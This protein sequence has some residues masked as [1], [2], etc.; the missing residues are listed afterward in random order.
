MYSYGCFMHKKLSVPLTL[1]KSDNPDFD[2]TFVM[3]AATL[4]RA[5]D[6]IDVKAY[7]DVIKSTDKIIALFNHCPDKICGYWSDLKVKGDTLVGSI[8]LFHKD[9]GAMCK[10]MLDFGIPLGASLG[11]IGEGLHRNTY[12]G[13]YVAGPKRG[14]IGGRGVIGLE[15]NFDRDDRDRLEPFGLN[16]IVFQRGAGLMIAGNKTAQQSIKSA[17]SS[18]DL[19]K[20]ILPSIISEGA[21]ISQPAFA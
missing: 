21:I 18:A 17:L 3:S 19:I 14:I 8:K 9:W 20:P 15:K 12:I 11:F 13:S 7:S 4:D 10:E 1:K 6:T 5:G 16:P 2:A